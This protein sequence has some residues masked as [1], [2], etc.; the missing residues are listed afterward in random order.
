MYRLR[1]ASELERRWRSAIEHE[2]SLTL[3]TSEGLTTNVVFGHAQTLDPHYPAYRCTVEIQRGANRE[4]HVSAQHSDGR[5]AIRHALARA[6]RDLARTRQRHVTQ[7]M[8][9]ERVL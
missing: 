1:I 9:R 7:I 4:V 5:H 8:S 2:L 6:K 3:P